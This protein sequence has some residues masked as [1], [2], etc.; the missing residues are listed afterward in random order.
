[1]T[2]SPIITGVWSWTNLTLVPPL[3]KQLRTNTG[4]WIAATQINVSDT[5][6]GGNDRGPGMDAIRA[7]DLIRLEH[8]TDTTRYVIYSVIEDSIAFSG[9]H[10][11]PVFYVESGGTLPANNTLLQ[12]VYVPEPPIP[13]PTPGHM[14]IRILMK[15]YVSEEMV[16]DLM[17]NMADAM[18]QVT[19][20]V[21][22]AEFSVNVNGNVLTYEEDI[23][24]AVVGDPM[25]EPMLPPVVVLP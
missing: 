8:N 16:T 12:I 5:D 18:Q 23:L 17:H 11:I 1:M 6:D 22:Y 10:T 7:G 14:W 25:V 13:E 2:E 20:M 9:Y 4:D 15:P 19:H 3:S 21:D 24:P